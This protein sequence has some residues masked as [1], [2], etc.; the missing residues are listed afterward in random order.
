MAHA[1]FKIIRSAD[2]DSQPVMSSHIVGSIVPSTTS[3]RSRQLSLGRPW[4]SEFE[5]Q[6][7]T[8]RNGDRGKVLE[9]FVVLIRQLHEERFG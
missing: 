4:R 5:Q 9:I 6:P 7:Q 2:V 8:Q 1:F 3:V